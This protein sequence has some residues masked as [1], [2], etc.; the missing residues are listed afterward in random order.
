MPSRWSVSCWTI[1]A[2]Q[3]LNT[4]ST[5]RPFSSSPVSR[6]W[7][8]RATTACQPGTLRQP[9]KNA[10]R[11]VPTGSY[12]GFDQ[13]PERLRHPPTRHP[14]LFRYGRRILDD[15]DAQGHP[16]LRGGQAHARRRVHGDAQGLDETGQDR[17]VQLAVVRLGGAPQDRFAGRHDR[18]RTVRG[19]EF[20]D[21]LGKGRAMTR[22]CHR[23]RM[24]RDQA[25][26]VRPM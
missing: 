15:R 5:G 20:L 2:G 9:S 4:S 24:P 6:T 3:P 1:R 18:Q 8:G 22:S 12:D 16:H 19:Q 13:H 10:A 17:G 25:S 26:R 11:S 23:A 7:A 14:Y 21:Q